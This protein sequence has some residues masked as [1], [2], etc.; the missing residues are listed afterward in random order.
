MAPSDWG[1]HECGGRF[2]PP[3]DI[4]TLGVR[5]ALGAAY[6]WCRTR[7]AFDLRQT[8]LSEHETLYDVPPQYRRYSKR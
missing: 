3:E 8:A 4:V 7:G 1:R 2:T 6:E 5:I